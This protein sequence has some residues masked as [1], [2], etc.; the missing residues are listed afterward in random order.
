MKVVKKIGIALSIIVGILLALFLIFIGY[1]FVMPAHSLFGYRLANYSNNKVITT[2]ASVTGLTTERIVLNSGAYQLNV[3]VSDEPSSV[4]SAITSRDLFGLVKADQGDAKYVFEFDHSTNTLLGNIYEPE[5]IKLRGKCLVDVYLSASLIAD[6]DYIQFASTSGA[7]YVGGDLE[8]VHDNLHIITNSGAVVLDN[9]NLS[10]EFTADIKSGSITTT[11]RTKLNLDKTQISVSRGKINFAEKGAGLYTF[12]D[13]VVDNSSTGYLSA[14]NV[15]TLVYNGNGGKVNITT[16]NS[17]DLNAVNTNVTIGKV[18]NGGYINIKNEGSI[19]IDET[20]SYCD[21]YTKA[22][23]IVIN[24]ANSKLSLATN[25][26]AI[27]VKSATE[28]VDAT[29]GSGN[30][31]ITFAEN[32]GYFIGSNSLRQAL[33][34][35][36]SG[37]V[38]LKGV[39]Y[40][41]VESQSS[42]SKVNVSF[43]NIADAESKI[44]TKGAPV[45]ILAPKGNSP[46]DDPNGD[47]YAIT[48]VSTTT[49]EIYAGVGRVEHGADNVYQCYAYGADINTVAKLVINTESGYVFVTNGITA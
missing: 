29:T 21:L 13:F 35:T 11:E 20:N 30:I 44:S 18:N 1:L 41:N 23:K 33:I 24:Q 26:G 42:S 39:D 36:R 43:H 6:V 25:S 12:G 49:P 34:T 4:V 15:D 19:N 48:I 7:I 3:I 27:T 10:D 32:V 47:K 14:T 37:K 46:T 16:I 45:S 9:V 17:V 5:G 8:F 31:D 40:V 22:G 28:Y 38:N 2:R